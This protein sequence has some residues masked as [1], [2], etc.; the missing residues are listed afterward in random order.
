MIG[1]YSKQVLKVS[2]ARLYWTAGTQSDFDR[3]LYVKTLVND[4]VEVLPRD[5][6]TKI[7]NRGRFDGSLDRDVCGCQEF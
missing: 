3:D 5:F 2:D 7:D 1:E 4:L 6:G